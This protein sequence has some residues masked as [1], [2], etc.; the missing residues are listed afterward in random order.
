MD[1]EID[2]SDLSNQISK[3][4]VQTTSSH[5][6]QT[7][8]VSNIERAK[9]VQLVDVKMKVL[10]IRGVNVVKLRKIMNPENQLVIFGD[11]TLSGV[12]ARIVDNHFVSERNH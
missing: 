3:Q 12:C 8:S 11:S 6:V 1:D 5:H 7:T 4:H 10:R 2:V 9:A